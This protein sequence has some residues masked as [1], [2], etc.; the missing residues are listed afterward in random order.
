[1]TVHPFIEAE[2]QVG[3]S[4]KRAGELLEVSRAAFC[5]AAPAHPVPGLCR[6]RS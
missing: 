4:V 6:T 1:V 2:K 3:H 5:A